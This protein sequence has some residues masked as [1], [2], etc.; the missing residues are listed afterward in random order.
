ML[1]FALTLG[2]ADAWSGFASVA[3]TRLSIEERAA[4]AWAAL[5]S[6]DA[7]DQA[8]AVSEAVLKFS[9]YPLPTFLNPMSDARHWASLASLRERKAYAL[10]AY[11][12]LPQ[13]DRLAFR[14]HISEEEITA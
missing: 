3:I 12:A 8:E 2:E 7:P 6:L 1:G 10:A 5:R 14:K 11:E 9:G 4:L 13:R